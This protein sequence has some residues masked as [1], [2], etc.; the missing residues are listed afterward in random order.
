MKVVLPLL[1]SSEPINFNPRLKTR[2]EFFSLSRYSTVYQVLRDK[3]GLANPKTFLQ[4]RRVQKL[5]QRPY[6]NSTDPPTPFFIAI[7]CISLQKINRSLDII[8]LYESQERLVRRRFERLGLSPS[9]AV[10]YGSR[11]LFRN[12]FLSSADKW[13]R[14]R[15]ATS[16]L[17]VSKS[18]EDP[19]K[20]RCVFCN[21]GT[22]TSSHLFADCVKVAPLVE[23]TQRRVNNAFDV[24][25]SRADWLIF[26]TPERPNH[27]KIEELICCIQRI[28]YAARTSS[29]KLPC[30]I[31]GLLDR[32]LSL[33]EELNNDG[34]KSEH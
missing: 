31:E 4:Y 30:G 23:L 28:I 25:L 21:N 24:K 15:L 27:W 8:S 14:Y 29:S 19:R 17:F 16:S 34:G 12:P 33:L 20:R 7:G 18:Q 3:E 11:N 13:F 26:S 10:L 1:G 6:T 9:T 32:K 5:A 2:E 22:E